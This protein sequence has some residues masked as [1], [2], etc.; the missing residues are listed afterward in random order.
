MRKF[1]EVTSEKLI[2]VQA[3]YFFVHKLHLCKVFFAVFQEI[4]SFLG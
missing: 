1:F 3:D 2:L 4:K